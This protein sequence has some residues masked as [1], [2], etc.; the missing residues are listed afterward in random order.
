MNK[1]LTKLAALTLAVCA[2]AIAPSIGASAN[3]SVSTRNLIMINA[4]DSDLKTVDGSGWAVVVID[5]GLDSSHPYFKDANGNS[6]VIAEACRTTRNCAGGTSSAD[7]V[8]SAA[9]SGKTWH[10]THVAGIAVGNSRGAVPSAPRGVAGGASIM[11]VKVANANGAT[12]GS[13]VDLALQWVLTQKRAG[14]RIAS[15]NMSV[16][17]IVLY[18]GNCDKS[19]PTTKKLIDD[20]FAEGV[21]VVTASGNAKSTNGMT[22]PACLSNV[23]PVASIA[24]DGNVSR[25]SNVSAITASQGLLAPGQSVCSSVNRTSA[26]SGYGCTSGTSMAA[27]H[28]AGAIAILRQA[29]PSLSASQIVTALKTTPTVI[30]DTRAGGKITGLKVLDVAAALASVTSP[31]ATQTA[32]QPPTP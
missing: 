10:G 14:A 32:S 26:N 15:V 3:S 4:E 6:R 7:G 19:S 23:V 29:A 18:A 25:E 16:S 1:R 27:P 22:W 12:L 13:N 24:N 31:V 30:S 8:G 21:V 9:H 2:T 5:D 20:L 11:A 17:S 28:V